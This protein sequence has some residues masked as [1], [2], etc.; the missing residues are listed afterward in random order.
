MNSE[1]LAALADEHEDF[2]PRPVRGPRPVHRVSSCYTHN[3]WEP[4]RLAQVVARTAAALDAAKAEGAP[5]TALAFTGTSGSAVAFPL[6]AMHGWPIVHIG[7]RVDESHAC[8]KYR[9]AV[10][11]SHY[12]IVDDFTDTGAT[13]G[14][15]MSEIQDH[16]RIHNTTWPVEPVLTHVFLYNKD[17][18]FMPHYTEWDVYSEQRAALAAHP[19]KVWCLGSQ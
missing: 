7:K 16:W 13:I 12:A 18:D 3:I 6:A 2:R 4:E 11:F 5:F 10:E 1:T 8:T 9:G 14:R 19:P 17:R 15:I